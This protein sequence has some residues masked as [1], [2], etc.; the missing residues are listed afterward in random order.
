M[1]EA[2]TK[3]QDLINN[4]K[5]GASELTAEYESLAQET[6]AIRTEFDKY[7]EIIQVLNGCTKGT[8]E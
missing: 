2:A 3:E 8:K 6:N 4:L 5:T 1:H 7:Q